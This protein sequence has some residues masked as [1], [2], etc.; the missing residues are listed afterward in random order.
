MTTDLVLEQ[1]LDLFLAALDVTFLPST[2]LQLHWAISA[3]LTVH[4]LQ[5]LRVTTTQNIRKS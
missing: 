3:V 1:F 4:L 5:S 2:F